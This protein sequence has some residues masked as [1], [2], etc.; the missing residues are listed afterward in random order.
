MENSTQ[1][2]EGLYYKVLLGLLVLTAITFVQPG[3][4]LTESTIAAQLFIA[5][6]KAWLIVM[7]YMHLKGEKLIGILV[8]STMAIVAV[9]FII[10][11]IDV[12]GFQYQDISPI[13][14]DAF[15]AAS[16]HTQEAVHAVSAH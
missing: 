5:V 10:V 9:F 6:V 7:Y 8:L 2:A 13:T 15:N 3:L 11:G 12:A 16:V 1:S 4:F 14:Q